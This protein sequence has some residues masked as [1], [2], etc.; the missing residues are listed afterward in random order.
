MGLLK[1]FQKEATE[2]LAISVEL[3]S[4]AIDLMT[5]KA[6]DKKIILD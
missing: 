5:F 4:L 6:L 1:P 2:K 3:D